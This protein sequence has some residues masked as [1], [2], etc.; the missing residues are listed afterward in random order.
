M[1]INLKLGDM[2][3]FPYFQCMMTNI[4]K[5]LTRM[6]KM[7]NMVKVLMA[8]GFRFLNFL[9]GLNLASKETV[10]FWIFQT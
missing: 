7:R 8:L 4:N 6:I 3:S 5:K 2:T 10:F 1:S 9:D